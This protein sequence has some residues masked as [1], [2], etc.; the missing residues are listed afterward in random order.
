MSNYAKEYAGIFFKKKKATQQKIIKKAINY[1]RV[2][3]HLIE[4]ILKFKR[5]LIF[6]ICKQNP[7]TV[8]LRAAKDKKK[9]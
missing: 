9:L 8:F 7:I 2:F 6:F 3:K 4:K 1:F 5:C